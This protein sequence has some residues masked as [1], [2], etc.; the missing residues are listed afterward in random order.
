V[1]MSPEQALLAAKAGA[2]YASPFAGRI[3]NYIRD[4][5]GILYEKTDYFDH[6][7]VSTITQQKLQNYLNEFNDEEIASLYTDENVK[8]LADIAGNK[9]ISSGADLVEKIVKI[10]RVYGF[11][12]QIIASAMRNARQ[13]REMAE[14]GA[15]VITMGF[16]ILKDMFRHP[17]TTEGIRGFC[18]DVVPEYRALFEK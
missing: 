11:N 1:I 7:L 3:D 13:V 14:A 2:T 5:L 8:K 10:Y 4:N 17:K 15:H 9:G 18:Q 12:T 16:Q 6:S